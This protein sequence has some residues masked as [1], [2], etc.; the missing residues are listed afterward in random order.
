MRSPSSIRFLPVS[1]ASESA[2]GF[3]GCLSSPR[4]TATPPRLAPGCLFETKETHVFPKRAP[5]SLFPANVASPLRARWI[6]AC[7]SLLNLWTAF[8]VASRYPA[9]SAPPPWPPRARRQVALF[10]VRIV[11]RGTATP[12]GPR[13]L[14]TRLQR[15]TFEG[16]Q[17]P[18]PQPQRAPWRPETR[19]PRSEAA[20]SR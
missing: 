19:W 9:P 4:A 11:R 10:R 17:R 7:A 5:Q 6:A 14:S 2:P 8:V 15:C 12:R 1:R 13:F 16:T 20:A 3:P 18:A